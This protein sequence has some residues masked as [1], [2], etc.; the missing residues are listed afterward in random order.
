MPGVMER[1][2]PLV[3]GPEISQILARDGWEGPQL[4][5]WFK[6]VQGVTWEARTVVFQDG[7]HGLSVVLR[8]PEGSQRP[9]QV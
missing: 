8:G 2:G 4:G 3:E 7:R 9:V 1:S 6:T 5:R